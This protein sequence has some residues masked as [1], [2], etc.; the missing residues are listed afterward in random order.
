MSIE[1]NYNEDKK[2]L[3]AVIAGK[4]INNEMHSALEII[5]NS[6]HHPPNVDITWDLT[7]IS[8]DSISPDL[9]IRITQVREKFPQRANAN[10]AIVI[11]DEIGTILAHMHTVLSKHLPQNISVF[12]TIPEAENWLMSLQ[13]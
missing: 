11:S 5:V 8:L 1:L 4:S 3:Y 6:D 7:Q 13:T 12:K 2:Y 9:A 10:A